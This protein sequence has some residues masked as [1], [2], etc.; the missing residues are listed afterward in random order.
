MNLPIRWKLIVLLG[1]LAIVPLLIVAWNDIKTLALLGSRL[2]SQAGQALS[3]QAR[4]HLERQAD[5]F[6]RLI[7]LER[8]ALEMLVHLQAREITQRLRNGPASAESA[9]W[10]SDLSRDAP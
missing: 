10:L 5:D 1:A 9:L 8:M 7:V 2:A 4:E 3:D 6:A